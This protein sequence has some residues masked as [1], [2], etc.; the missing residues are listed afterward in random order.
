M[1]KQKRRRNRKEWKYENFKHVLALSVQLANYLRLLLHIE[2]APWDFCIDKLRQQVAWDSQFATFET[3]KKKATKKEK[4]PKGKLV[5][6]TV[7]GT[8]RSSRSGPAY[9]EWSKSKGRGKGRRYFAAPCDELGRVQKAVLDRFLSQVFVHFARY[10]GQVGSSIVANAEHHVGFAKTVFSLDIVNAY[11]TVYR[12]RIKATLNKPFT[13]AL[14]QFAGVTFE[15]AEQ[16]AMLNS[17]VDLLVFKDRLPQGPSSSP[18]VFD[19]VCGKM[20]QEIF[21]LLEGSSTAFQSYRY[22][23]WTDN[24]TISSDGPIP[25]ELR[26]SVVKIVRDCGFFPHTRED[27]MKYYSPETG[28]VPI[29]TGLVLNTDGRLTMA[30][31]K[32]NQLRA[33]LNRF[34]KLSSWDEKIVGEAAGTLGYISQVYPKRLPS[35][36]R[37]LVEAVDQRLKAFH[38]TE[39]STLTPFVDEGDEPENGPVVPPSD[40]EP[41]T[42]EVV[43]N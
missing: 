8:E 42:Q 12:S 43:L 32:V 24:L 20:D 5:K 13:F 27:K 37:A 1:A 11:P 3:R 22:S 40:K 23:A 17:L 39:P 38:A 28:E 4:E 10:G 2:K 7:K 35:K 18:R 9:F 14:R 15:E 34:M 41:G 31:R 21:K 16:E 19:I 6:I 36:L 30:P 29:V 33:R 25:E 26:D